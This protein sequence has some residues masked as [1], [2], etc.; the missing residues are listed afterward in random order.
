MGSFIVDDHRIIDHLDVKLLVDL[1]E[2]SL[3]RA[4]GD[5][6]LSLHLAGNSLM[7][8]PQNQAADKHTDNR[9]TPSLP[10]SLFPVC[11]HYFSDHRSGA[12]HRQCRRAPVGINSRQ[13]ARR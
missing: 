1:V 12:E 13:P 4:G 2:D 7:S 3:S 10:H 8:L 11:L 9:S 5:V 6:E